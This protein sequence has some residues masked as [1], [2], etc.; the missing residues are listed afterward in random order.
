[1]SASWGLVLQTNELA[2]SQQILISFTPPVHEWVSSIPH[3]LCHP[4]LLTRVLGGCWDA[5]L[6]PLAPAHLA[7][8]QR[9]KED[10]GL[11]LCCCNPTPSRSAAA[12]GPG[13]HPA[14][15]RFGLRRP[16][17]STRQTATE[18]GYAPGNPDGVCRR[19]GEE[20]GHVVQPCAN[21]GRCLAVLAW[22]WGSKRD[23]THEASEPVFDLGGGRCCNYDAGSRVSPKRT[24]KQGR[25]LPSFISRYRYR[26][27]IGKIAKV[28][29]RC[30]GKWPNIAT[31][32]FY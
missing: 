30:T 1:M 15:P 13:H 17:R 28:P 29:V 23:A 10:Q 22:G 20:A 9:C 12:V 19:R 25:N 31:F 5:H 11:D 14:T 7:C 32:D 2:V 18:I 6:I 16:P 24:K 26:Y 8:L 21:L 27:R 4:T 3:P